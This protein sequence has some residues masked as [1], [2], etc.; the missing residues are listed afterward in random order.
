MNYSK[1]K[2]EAGKMMDVTNRLVPAG[3]R[4]FW[5]G[6]D[7]VEFC[8]PGG[9][10]IVFTE[11]ISALAL[12]TTHLL[13]EIDDLKEKLKPQP[14][15]GPSEAK[16]NLFRDASRN[17]LGIR[18]VKDVNYDIEEMR[19]EVVFFCLAHYVESEVELWEMVRDLRK[20]HVVLREA[21]YSVMVNDE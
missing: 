8:D 16:C 10:R 6:R 4:V 2:Q 7:H 15:P 18:F 3:W 1:R 14:E 17:L 19:I 5:D 13:A 9:H 20:S 12:W 11:G 21:S